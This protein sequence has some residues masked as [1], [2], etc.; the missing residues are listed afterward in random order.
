M[1][2]NAGLQFGVR[3]GGIIVTE[4]FANVCGELGNCQTG[5]VKKSLWMEYSFH[6]HVFIDAFTL[7]SPTCLE[8]E[9]YLFGCKLQPHH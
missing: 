3:Y 2:T 1:T 5:F 9:R 8:R 7:A 6:N 4:I